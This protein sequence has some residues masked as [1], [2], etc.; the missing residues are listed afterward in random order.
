[1]SHSPNL[2]EDENR[3]A[4]GNFLLP[5]LNI[6]PCEESSDHYSCLG[7]ETPLYGIR[8]VR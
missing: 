8:I 5:D 1:M 6:M 4:D 2:A 7:V 3:K